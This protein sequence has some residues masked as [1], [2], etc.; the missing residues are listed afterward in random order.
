M[1]NLEPSVIESALDQAQLSLIVNDQL[2]QTIQDLKPLFP[3]LKFYIMSNISRVS[4]SHIYRESVVAD[5]GYRS[6][7]RWCSASACLGLCSISSLC[8]GKRA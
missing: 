8:Q 4:P 3:D 7:T 6:I 5:Q 2:V 1:L